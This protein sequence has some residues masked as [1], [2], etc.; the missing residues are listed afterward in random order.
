MRLTRGWSLVLGVVLAA[1]ADFGPS[2][3]L[4]F[5]WDGGPGGGGG[6]FTAPFYVYPERLTMLKG[7]TAQ[8]FTFSTE[9]HSL[10][11]WSVTGRALRFANPSADT[12]V[13]TAQ[14]RVW[15]RAIAAGVDTIFAKAADVELRDTSTFVAVDSS[16]ITAMAIYRVTGDTLKAGTAGLYETVLFAG[17]STAVR[18]TPTA[19]SSSDTTIVR[20]TA[21]GFPYPDYVPARFGVQ[22]TSKTGKVTLTFDFL[23]V[24][25]SVDLVV[26]P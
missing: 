8:L 18:G 12:A 26:V 14:E 6:P 24:R 4:E 25:S 1:C 2:V 7:D 9:N 15:V 19:W 22:A 5:D 3:P 20:I 23:A 21:P 10:A 16:A 11:T 13:S 17:P